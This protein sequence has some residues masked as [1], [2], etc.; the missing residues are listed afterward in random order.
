VHRSDENWDRAEQAII[1]ATIEKDATTIVKGEA[2]FMAP[3]R[4]M[5]KDAWDGSG[6]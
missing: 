6:S 4:F 3:S 2:Y 5:V 1:E